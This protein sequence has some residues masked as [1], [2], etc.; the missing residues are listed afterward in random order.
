MAWRIGF[1]I[2]FKSF[3]HFLKTHFSSERAKVFL[4]LNFR[5]QQEK[6]NQKASQNKIGCVLMICSDPFNFAKKKHGIYF[7]DCIF[8]VRF[9]PTTQWF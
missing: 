6:N 8:E 7:G 5:N 4:I 2:S 3:L 1:G 9:E